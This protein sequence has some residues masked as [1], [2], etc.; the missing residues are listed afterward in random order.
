M[1]AAYQVCILLQKE[2]LLYTIHGLLA[3]LSASNY[4]RMRLFS[5]HRAL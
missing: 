2:T 3:W 4:F 5:L 1:L